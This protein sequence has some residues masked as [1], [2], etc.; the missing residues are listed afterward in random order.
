[1][2]QVVN[3]R[4]VVRGAAW[5]IPVVAVAANAP[6]YAA[7]T[8]APVIGGAGSFTVCRD[9]GLGSN[10]QGYRFS[11]TL[12][13]QPGDS[14]NIDFTDV[15][16]KD[17]SYLG[18]DPTTGLPQTQPTTFTVNSDMN[19]VTFNVCGDFSASQIL[20]TLRYTAT[21]TRTGA[22]TTNLGGTYKFDQISNKCAG[23]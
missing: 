7:S 15:R 21:N 12:T 22:A 20:F 6:A 9:T 10:C 8:D 17:V 3:R 23:Q 16:I 1:M 19:I 2:T 13:V 5:S 4:A 14:W 11:L 18:N